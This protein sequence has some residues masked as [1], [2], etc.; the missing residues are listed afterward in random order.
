MQ[1]QV[2]TTLSLCANGEGHARTQVT[3]QLKQRD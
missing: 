1:Q 2:G 3:F